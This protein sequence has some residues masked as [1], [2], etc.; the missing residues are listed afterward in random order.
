MR[1]GEACDTAL[2]NHISSTS[3]VPWQEYRE[4]EKNVCMAIPYHLFFGPS[5]PSVYLKFPQGQHLDS[6]DVCLLYIV[7]L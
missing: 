1:S 6:M 5:D 7:L 4:H 3:S 2:A